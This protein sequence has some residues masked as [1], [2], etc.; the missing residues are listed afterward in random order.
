VASLRLVSCGTATDCVTFFLKKLTTFFSHCRLQSS[1]LMT[2]F[3]SRY[4]TTPTFRHRLSS[5]LSKFSHKKLV[6]TCNPLNG[7]TRGAPP[8]LL[9]PYSDATACLAP[10]PRYGGLL[11]QFSLS[12]G[13][14]VFNGLVGGESLN[15]G[16]QNVASRNYKHSSI[17][18]CM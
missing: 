1:D 13:V 16:V 6:R 3:S 7:V 8:P 11:V 12:T 17:V 10:F 2:Y 14:P 18:R 5:L 15:F 9:S 4:L